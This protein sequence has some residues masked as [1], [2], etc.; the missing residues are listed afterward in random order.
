M[1]RIQNPLLWPALHFLIMGEIDILQVATGDLDRIYMLV[2]LVDGIYIAQ[3]GVY[4]YYEFSPHRDRQVDDESWRLML[5]H[6][7]PDRPDWVEK[8]LLSDGTA[9]DVLAYRI[10]DVYRVLPDAGMLQ[11][12]SSPFRDAGVVQLAVPGEYLEIVSGPVKANGLEWWEVR[13]SRDLS[14]TFQGWIV[15]NQDWIERAWK[16]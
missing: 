15:E 14:D 9:V 7:P 13:L 1:Q 8:S 2:P 3:G 4:S 10:G 16:R 6:S 5:I 12:R 11:L